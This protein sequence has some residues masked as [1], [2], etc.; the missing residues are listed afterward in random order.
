MERRRVPCSYSISELSNQLQAILSL[1]FS[2][3]RE[4]EELWSALTIRRLTTY[5]KIILR[6]EAHPVPPSHPQPIRRPLLMLPAF[7]PSLHQ[8]FPIAESSAKFPG[9]FSDNSENVRLR[10]VFRHLLI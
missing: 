3:S 5:G 9:P 8:P 6:N 2:F 1:D 10:K 7:L 4:A